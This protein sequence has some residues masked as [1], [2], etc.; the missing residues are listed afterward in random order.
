MNV[1]GADAEMIDQ[2]G[3]QQ[4]AG[5]RVLFPYGPNLGARG[6][7]GRQTPEAWVEAQAKAGYAVWVV[8]FPGADPAM[9]LAYAAAVGATGVAVDIESDV[10]EDPWSRQQAAAFGDAAA[11]AKVRAAIY[12]H[13]KAVDN[14][15]GGVNLSAHFPGQWWAGGVNQTPPPR[16]AIQY[17]QVPGPPAVDLNICDSWYL[18][19]APPPPPPDPPEDPDVLTPQQAT[20]LQYLAAIFDSGDPNPI[21]N[22]VDVI[23][24][25]RVP[26]TASLQALIDAIIPPNSVPSEVGANYLAWSRD[27]TAALASLQAAVA[28][29]EATVRTL[30]VPQAST[31]PS[32]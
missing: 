10:E 30:A 12:C 4:L 17:G 6:G 28:A 24:W 5:Y 3:P 31:P 16:V 23:G 13:Q 14:G 2:V 11:I 15:A 8:F 29:L 1:P 7:P 22:G 18:D 20:Q 26:V 32:G 9:A 27:V 19:P 25:T 21:G